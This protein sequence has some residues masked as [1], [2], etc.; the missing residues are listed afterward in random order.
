MARS[1]IQAH[2]VAVVV[3]VNAEGA[4]AHDAVNV[5][6]LLIAQT[7]RDVADGGTHLTRN[8]RP[9]PRT[10]EIGQVVEL[11]RA[12]RNGLIGLRTSPDAYTH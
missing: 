3:F 10:A 11:G 5:G 8:T 12:V 4:D 1:R 2:P 6:E 7:L 9:G